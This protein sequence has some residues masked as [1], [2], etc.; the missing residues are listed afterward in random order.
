MKKTSAMISTTL[1][2]AGFVLASLILCKTVL[3]QQPPD[4]VQGNW[5]IYSTRI[6]DGQIEVKHVQIS[7]YGN[8]I[9]GY[10]EGPNQSGPIEGEV[11]V[12]HIR[13]STVTRN[14][15]NFHGQIYGD[16]MSGEYGLHGRHAQ[17]QAQRNPPIAEAVPSAPAYNYQPVLTPAVATEAAP[18][19]QTAAQPVAA[20]QAQDSSDSG[21]TPSPLSSDQ[22]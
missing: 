21:P 1:K 14:V 7:Q 4:N 13:F 16:N 15:L 3:A 2:L 9:T 22:L 18:E 12:H 10:F 8:R 20:F 5:I 17:W 11:N 6:Q 19:S